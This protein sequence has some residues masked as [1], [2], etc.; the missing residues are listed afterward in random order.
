VNARSRTGAATREL[1]EWATR[2]EFG[3]IPREVAARAARVI[4]DDLAAIVAARDEP[5][6]HCFHDRLLSAGGA[7]E[8]TLFRGGRART[9]RLRAAAGNALA[10]NWLEVEEGYRKASCHAGLFTL[11]AL[12]AEAES[13]R[14]Y[15]RDVLRALS[16]AYEIVTR[17]A[18]GWQADD[19]AIHGH[20]RFSAIGAAAA[21]ALARRLPAQTMLGA[22][23]GA[24]TLLTAGPHDHAIEGALVRNAWPAAGALNGMMS[25]TW[26][27]CGIMGLPEGLHDV[28][29]GVLHGEAF[30][31]RM[32]EGLSS[33]WAVMDGY[34]KMHACC[35]FAHSTV[36]AVL[37]AR[38]DARP[39]DVEE[40]VVATHRL[41]LPMTNAAPPTTL[42][43]KFSLPHIVA[44]TLVHGHA[45]VAAFSSAMLNAPAIAALRRRVKV[46]SFGEELAPPNDRPARVTIRLAD[47]RIREST[48]LSA[49]GGP[50]RPFSDAMVMHKIERL[51][52]RVYPRFRAVMERLIALEPPVLDATWEAVVGE[53]TASDE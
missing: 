14:M 39:E 36:E 19:L 32:T 30:P 45:D 6:V 43:G 26:A 1:I 2:V 52:A 48:C 22:I 17:I 46:V 31:E 29:S 21:T 40:I 49:A 16:A 9:D 3:A 7:A 28:F 23:T 27:S 25:A 47:G 20:A 37:A 11:P 4:A 15:V 13:E 38:A 34:S 50:D 10:A 8:A 5:E 33:S 12:L 44:T 35:Q 51:T 18:R 41:A 24:A 53:L 42:A